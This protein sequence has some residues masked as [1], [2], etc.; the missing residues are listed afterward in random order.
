MG[1]AIF[2]APV[3]GYPMI[4]ELCSSQHFCNAY[5]CQRL[6]LAQALDYQMRLSKEGAAF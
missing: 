4:F 3:T 2:L 6:I 1:S 5:Y